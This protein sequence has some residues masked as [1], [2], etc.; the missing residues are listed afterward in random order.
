MEMSKEY[1]NLE[2]FIGSDIERLH[3]IGDINADLKRY[4]IKVDEKHD[5]IVIVKDGYLEMTKPIDDCDK[6]LEEIQS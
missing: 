6:I 4:I 1:Y 3:L 5:C 2:D